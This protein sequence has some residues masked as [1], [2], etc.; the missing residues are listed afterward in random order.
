MTSAPFPGSSQRD[1]SEPALRRARPLLGTL[2]DIGAADADP[3]RAAAAIGAAFDRIAAIQSRLSRFDDASEIGR[4]NIAPAGACIAVG[5]ETRAVLAAA[6][7]LCDASEG[8]FDV[9][10]GSGASAWR[11]DDSDLH[12]L[13]AGVRLDLG[14]IAK[15]FAVD[16]GV[17]TLAAHGVASGWVN[18]GGDL[19]VFGA[20]T[21][22][23]DLRDETRGGVR[24]FATLGD[25]AFATSRLGRGHPGDVRPGHASVAA[26]ECMWADALTKIVIASGDAGHPLLARFAARAWCH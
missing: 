25:G 23:I 2:V 20:L 18:A 9:S 21:L 7:V 17:A 8:L 15:G 16:A 22:P 11:C 19:R 6:R 1:G 5:A 26:S 13:S 4:F 12:K 14:G 10:L 24:R 3:A